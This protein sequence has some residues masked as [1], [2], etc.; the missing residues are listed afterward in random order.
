MELATSRLRLRPYADADAADLYAWSADPRVG[1]IAGWRPHE[2]LEES[3]SVIRT[4]LSGPDV[5]ALEEKD[6]GR[7]I[8][9]IGLTGNHPLGERPGCPDGEIGY[10]LAPMYW[11]RGLMT[12]AMEA[13]LPVLFREKGLRQVWGA[14]YAGNWRSSR[15][16]NKCGFRYQNSRTEEVADLGEVRLTYFYVLTKEAWRERHSGAL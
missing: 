16:L 14:H 4:V 5:F 13:F 8:G 9:S 3:L 6:S 12:E 11:G 10:A 1:P 7:V 15:V 2:S